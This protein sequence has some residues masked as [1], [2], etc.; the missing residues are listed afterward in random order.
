MDV[1]RQANVEKMAGGKDRARS[2]REGRASMQGPLL[3]AA[4]LGA[5][6]KTGPEESKEQR[7]QLGT[8]SCNERIAI[9]I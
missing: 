2:P 1:N 9:L 7:G 4:S 5:H 6:L 3:L 8:S